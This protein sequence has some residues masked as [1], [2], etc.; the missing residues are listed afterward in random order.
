MKTNSNKI[1]VRQIYCMYI[2]K[3]QRNQ[4]YQTK[5]I[6]KHIIISTISYAGCTCVE[7]HRHWQQKLENKPSTELAVASEHEGSKHRCQE[8]V[9]GKRYGVKQQLM[10]RRQLFFL[11]HEHSKYN[12]NTHLYLLPG[13]CKILCLSMVH[14]R[15]R[16]IIF[17][18]E[19]I[20]DT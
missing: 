11:V 20:N 12:T 17:T 5:T 15:T 6:T 7:Y 8:Y 14:W 2:P 16:H 10:C 19:D 4:G 1:A 13:I 3:T 9:T 18:N